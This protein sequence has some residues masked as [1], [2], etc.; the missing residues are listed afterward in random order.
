MKIKYHFVLFYMCTMDIDMLYLHEL[1]ACVS[2]DYHV[3]L[4]T[5]M[6]DIEIFYLHVLS[7]YVSWDLYFVLLYICKKD[8]EMF[9]LHEL[10]TTVNSF[11]ILGISMLLEYNKPIENTKMK[12]L[13]VRD[14]KLEVLLGTWAFKIKF[15]L[16]QIFGQCF[17]P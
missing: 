8:I 16:L 17:W 7:L 9:Y 12:Y 15:I 4:Y 2:W 6:K 13:S 14:E 5:H 11:I 3:F 10:I 1:I